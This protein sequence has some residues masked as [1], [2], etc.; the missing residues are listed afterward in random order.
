[1]PDI[2]QMIGARVRALRKERRLSQEALGGKAGLHTTYVGAV[3][4]GERNVSIETL[5]KIADGLGVKIYDLLSCLAE[6]E[7]TGKM[8][9]YITKSIKACP[10]GAVKIIF[11]VMNV[12]Q[13]LENRLTSKKNK[14]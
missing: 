7:D 6:P 3:E 9:A 12:L 10:P 8:K 13:N 2:K 11:D 5:E 1:M 14:N 4:R